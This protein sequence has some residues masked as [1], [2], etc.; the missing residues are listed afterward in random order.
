MNV[1]SPYIAPKR[2]ERL[3]KAQILSPIDLREISRA[4]IS[5]FNEV[6]RQA[7]GPESVHVV[8]YA[9]RD[10]VSCN[11]PRQQLTLNPRRQP[12]AAVKRHIETAAFRYGWSVVFHKPHA[13][14]RENVVTAQ[15][16]SGRT[17]LVTFGHSLTL[18]PKGVVHVD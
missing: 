5:G 3:S 8:R 18:S 4:W 9:G 10:I 6:T 17:E 2:G 16:S 11:Q 12:S 15:H 7:N 14:T 1:N 13:L